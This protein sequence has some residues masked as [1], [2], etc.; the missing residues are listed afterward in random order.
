MIGRAGPVRILRHRLLSPKPTEAC[1]PVAMSEIVHRRTPRW[2][3]TDAGAIIRLS[4]ANWVPSPPHLSSFHPTRPHAMYTSDLAGCVS[5][6]S[7]PACS[8]SRNAPDP[9]SYFARTTL[10]NAVV[11]LVVPFTSGCPSSVV[12][13]VPTSASMRD[14]LEPSKVSGL[15]AVREDGLGK[16]DRMEGP[17]RRIDAGGLRLD[18]SRRTI[19]L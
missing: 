3:M 15:S 7:R 4:L 17:V 16:E 9:R 6:R 14:A 2:T 12:A 19:P 8:R 18:R 5:C 11:L 13:T 10:L 1:T